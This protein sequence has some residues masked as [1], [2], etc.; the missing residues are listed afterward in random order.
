M[1]AIIEKARKMCGMTLEDAA[2]AFEVTI[3]TVL[4]Y[5]KNPLNMRMGSFKKFYDA[6]GTD[7]KAFLKDYF[8]N[9]FFNGTEV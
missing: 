7:S 9:T 8:E 2:K 5:Q 1:N 3:P 4:E 6:V